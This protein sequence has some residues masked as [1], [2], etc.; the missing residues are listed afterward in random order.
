MQWRIIQL[1][2]ID[3]MKYG[4]KWMEGK[5]IIL[6]K[7]AQTQKG[8]HNMCSLIS[9]YELLNKENHTIIHRKAT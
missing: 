6:S 3:V 9:G 1:L 4:G 2:K 5:N 7:A 8:K